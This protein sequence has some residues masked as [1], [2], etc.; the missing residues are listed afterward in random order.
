VAVVGHLEA[1]VMQ[2]TSTVSNRLGCCELLVCAVGSTNQKK[3]QSQPK[4]DWE[5]FEMNP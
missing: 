5:T 4:S 3:P 2:L 1:A